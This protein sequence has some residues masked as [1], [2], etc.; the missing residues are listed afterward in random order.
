[1]KYQ[2]LRET[3]ASSPKSDWD[4]HVEQAVDQDG[5]LEDLIQGQIQGLA[6]EDVSMDEN[7]IAATVNLMVLGDVVQDEDGTYQDEDGASYDYE[8]EDLTFH[9]TISASGFIWTKG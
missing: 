8:E 4:S 5:S 7:S 3:L 2:Q 1:M 6:I 9:L